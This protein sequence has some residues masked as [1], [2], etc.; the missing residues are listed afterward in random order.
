MLKNCAK[1][2][3]EKSI[4]DFNYRDRARGIKRSYCRDCE[5]IYKQQHYQNNKA[6]Y[7]KKARFHTK[8]YVAK[9]RVLVYEFKLGNP[10]NDCGETDPIVLEFNHLAPEDKRGHVSEM[11]NN[12]YS[13]R[14]I[15]DE[16]RK[17]VI[18]CANCHRRRTA[19]DFEYYTHTSDRRL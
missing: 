19:K 17:C 8:R 4:E 18:L 7:K 9:A 15:M 12:G 5:K 13:E 1:C 2:Y 3:E 10:C 11:V 14:T 6:A 16:I